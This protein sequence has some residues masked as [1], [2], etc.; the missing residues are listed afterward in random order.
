MRSRIGIFGGTFDPVHHGHLRLAL[1]IKQQLQLDEMR[2]MPC[3][4]PPHRAAPGVT[5]QQRVAMVRLAIEHCPALQVDERELKREQASYTID[6]LIDLRRELGDEASLLWVLG[7]DAFIGLDTWHRWQE[8]LDY[9]HLV[10]VARPGFSLPVN[11][12]VAELLLAKQVSASALAERA[13]GG[14]FLPDLGLLPISSTAIRAQIAR[15][16]SPQYLLPEAVWDYIVSG[17]FYQ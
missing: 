6:T 5:S 17:R 13:Q 3:H 4:R 2:L 11:G 15:G 16:Q 14:I 1:E 8:L 9:A 12:Q 10:V 7:M